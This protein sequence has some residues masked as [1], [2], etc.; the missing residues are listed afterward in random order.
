MDKPSP[1]TLGHSAERILTFLSLLMPAFALPFRPATLTSMPSPYNG[2]L[3][4][5]RIITVVVILSAAS[6]ND[7]SPVTSSA[8]S[9]SIGELLRTL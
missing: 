5:H 3:P 9:G 2:T 8:Q 6:V 1:G 4:Y 7:F